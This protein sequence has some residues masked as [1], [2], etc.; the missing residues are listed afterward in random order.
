MEGDKKLPEGWVKVRSRSR[1]DKEYYFN[2][3]LKF[4]C[5][6]FE[7]LKNF[8]K[9]GECSSNG[10]KKASVKS[11][12]KIAS[13]KK[14]STGTA[15]Q[16]RTITKKNVARDRMIKLQKVLGDEVLRGAP[17]S[18]QSKS[19]VQRVPFVPARSSVQRVPFVPA[20]VQKKNIASERMKRMSDSLVEE[21]KRAKCDTTSKHATSTPK[22]RKL[23]KF[24]ENGSRLE[25][26][27][28]DSSV[29][30]GQV[31]VDME[32][33]SLDQSRV[34]SHQARELPEDFEPMEWE[35]V[36]ELEVIS[37]VQKIR[38]AATQSTTVS[39][40][41]ELEPSENKFI[42]VVDTNVLLSNID[43]LKE[44]KGKAFK[45][46]TNLLSCSRS[47]FTNNSFNR[48]WKIYNLSS[49]H[50]PVRTG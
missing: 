26:K 19:S 47:C 45:G 31:D 44:I 7:D 33:I 2:R 11:P 41:Q 34:Q 28:S 36:P 13:P 4:S 8:Q 27:R 49:L 25:V 32:D 6:R 46:K 18:D 43:F 14:T 30:E 1:P 12:K 42:I 29:D 21:V 3:K 48:Y 50:C 39:T 40:I 37:K 9:N 20:T 5:W 35:D 17:N 10:T 24:T 23:L 15:I 38:T 22:P 16:S